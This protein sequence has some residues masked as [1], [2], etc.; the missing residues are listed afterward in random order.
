MQ[1]VQP[2]STPNIRLNSEN[3]KICLTNV[4]GWTE[5]ILN[6]ALQLNATPFGPEMEPIVQQI[7]ALGN[8][9]LKGQDANKNGQYDEAISGECG[10][11]G[12]YYYGYYMADMFIY[13]GAD[14]VP[15]PE[16]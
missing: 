14:R 2:N 6:L 1:P 3:V 16:K 13:P 8:T 11:T 7:S 12:G 9:L 5:Q 10:A 15:P 4:T